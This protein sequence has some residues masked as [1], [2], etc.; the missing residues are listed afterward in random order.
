MQFLTYYIVLSQR[1]LYTMKK[2]R[3]CVIKKIA[4]LLNNKKD[5]C[6]QFLINRQLL[7][8]L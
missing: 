3:D 5:I 6:E 1:K 2:I 8:G 7:K 4:K